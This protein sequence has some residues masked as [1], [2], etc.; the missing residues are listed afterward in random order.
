VQTEIRTA[1][2]Q[3]TFPSAFE[4]EMAVEKLRR[5]TSRRYDQITAYLIKVG[6]MT[7]RSGIKKNWSVS[8]R[9]ELHEEWK[10]S[11]VVTKFYPI[12]CCQG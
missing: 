5:H 9:E 6:D 1:E 8:N 10:E 7:V 11:I 2:A 3:P 4:V 12:S